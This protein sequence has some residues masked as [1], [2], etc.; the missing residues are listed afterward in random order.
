MRNDK[1]LT[2]TALMPILWLSGL[3]ALYLRARIFLGHWPIPSIDDPKQL[4][5]EMH[6]AVLW[7]MT[8]PLLAS[9]PLTASRFARTPPS[10][11]EGALFALS[12]CALAGSFLFPKV[13][14]L[15][16]FLD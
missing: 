15:T 4:P 3:W 14:L 11:R 9:I 2:V 10:S 7:I 12:W 5:F 13:P 16:W 8:L 6:H 1:W